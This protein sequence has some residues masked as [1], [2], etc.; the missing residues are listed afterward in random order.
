MRAVV[1]RSAAGALAVPSA[2]DEP[3]DDAA[4]ALRQQAVA[5]WGRP[6]LVS[7]A[8]LQ[9]EVSGA[10]VELALGCDLRVAADDVTLGLPQ[11]AGGTVPH[12]GGTAALAAVVGPGRAL[13]LCL[14]GRRL[15]A[16]QA[17]A[18][19]L[20][21]LSVPAADLDAAAT[22]LLAA[23]LAAPRA[24]V[25]ETKSLMSGARSRTTR[26]QCEAERRA[27]LRCL[28]DLRAG[29][30]DDADDPGPS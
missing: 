30:H 13:E 1:L 2:L 28:R 4:L 26:E 25:A 17:Q 7:V 14:T 11:A 22:D 12:L 23:L 24:A 18:W 15:T 19:G 16:A 21:T 3:V 20:V 29:T 9:G 10:G 5:W 6:D 8:V 27:Q